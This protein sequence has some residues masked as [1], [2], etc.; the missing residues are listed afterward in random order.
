MWAGY[1]KSIQHDFYSSAAYHDFMQQQGEGEALL[2]VAGGCKKFLVWPFL[3]RSIDRDSGRQH[4]QPQDITSVYG[5]GGPL[6]VGCAPG[7]PFVLSALDALLANWRAAGVVSVFCR[8]HPL[9]ENHLW[10]AHESE[11]ASDTNFARS[12]RLTH[13]GRTVSLDLALTDDEAWA[14]YRE[15]H[16]RHIARARR[17]GLTWEFDHSFTHLLDFVRL[18]QDTMRRNGAAAGY[19]FGVNYFDGLRRNLDAVISLHLV[20]AGARVAAAALVSEYQGNVQYLFGG[21]DRDFLD[22][23]PLKFLLEGIRRWARSRGDVVLH[24]GGGRGGREDSLFHFKSGF[25]RRRHPFYTGRYI[26]DRDLY[27]FLSQEHLLGAEKLGKSVD[28][29][30]FPAYR[31]PTNDVAGEQNAALQA[32]VE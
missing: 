30:F 16:R 5:Y 27:R 24:L 22:L 6:A 18:Y 11:S 1:L 31:A 15:T 17:L 8:F 32:I 14:G 13:E 23:S 21:V 4:R 12:F 19:F 20:R 28:P 9:L 3:L 29:N 10:V 25:S 2:A 26:L 7:D